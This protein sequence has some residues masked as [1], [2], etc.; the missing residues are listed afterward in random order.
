MNIG[1]HNTPQIIPIEDNRF[2]TLGDFVYEWEI[3]GV[4][5]RITIKAGQIFDGAS[6]PAFATFMTWALPGFDTI[7]PMGQHIYAALVHDKIWEYRGRL[8]EGLHQKQLANGEW[9][10][11]AYDSKGKPVWT[12]TAS[13]KLFIRM[14]REDG[15]PKKERRAM[16]L[17]VQYTPFA[18]FNWRTGKLP[19]DARPKRIK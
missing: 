14:L 11:A 6:I 17:A 19:K 3:N 5:Q 2:K 13:N 1:K 8:P 10:D 12:R 15:V 9:V 16:Y 18:W 4:K 7:Y